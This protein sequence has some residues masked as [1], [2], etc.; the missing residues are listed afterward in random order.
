MKKIYSGTM[1][2]LLISGM[3]LLSSCKKYLEIDPPINSF[4]AANAFDNDDLVQADITGLYSYN[5]L[6]SSYHDIYRH[7]YPG[8]SADELKYYTPS[9]NDEFMYN[10]ILPNN[11]ASRYMW[12]EPYKAIYQCN[13]MLEALNISTKISAT[14]KKE[15]TAVAQFFR[16]LSYL[17]LVS[18][19]GDVP[20]VL[21]SSANVS[22]GLPRATKEAVY[23]QIIKDLT[24]AKS[25]IAGSTKN[26]AYVNEKNVTAL[27]ARAYLYHEKWQLAADAAK[28]LTEGALKVDIETDIKKVFLRSSKETLFAISSDGSFKTIINH[29][30]AGRT[31]IPGTVR[32]IYNLHENFVAAFETG[33]L[34]K[35]NWIKS[36]TSSSVGTTW[37]PF[38]YKLNRN[39]TDL[40][41]AED[42][43][44]IRMSEVYLIRA[45]ALAQLTQTTDAIG[46]INTIRRR[47][48]LTDLPTTLNKEQT[49][50]AVE[51][52]RRVE[53]FSEYGHR[54]VDLV[55]T[56]R[57]DAVLQPLKPTTWKST[58]VLYPI[59]FKELELN[60][61]LT[62]NPGYDF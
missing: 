32:T 15:A 38:K 47:A 5:L 60:R 62:Q 33:D 10:D 49:L 30:Y 2:T 56:G 61:A 4:V 26:A 34:R 46:Y 29:T 20:L 35:T 11:T 8:Y 1:V 57:A 54:W 9:A 53:L 48:G 42:Q 12:S 21:Q 23:T 41:Q 27:L 58:D 36:F 14:V 17:N 43:I 55:R 19:F 13:I 18:L 59:D 24:E 50:L 31:Y 51:K 45:E 16:A 6:S 28:E 25:L 44:L 3:L 22:K 37:Y 7:V 52:E 40:T 39:P